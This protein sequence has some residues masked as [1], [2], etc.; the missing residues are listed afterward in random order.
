MTLEVS[1]LFFIFLYLHCHRLSLDEPILDQQGS[2]IAEHQ[3]SLIDV[4]GK[5]TSSLVVE[6]FE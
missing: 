6:T 2:H 1:R 3:L 4:T 5:E